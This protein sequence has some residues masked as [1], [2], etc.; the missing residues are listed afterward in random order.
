[1]PIFYR[2]MVIALD[3]KVGTNHKFPGQNQWEVKLRSGDGETLFVLRGSTTNEQNRALKWGRTFW[4]SRIVEGPITSRHRAG[5]F[6]MFFVSLLA[7]VETET[8]KFS[9][10]LKY[11]PYD[12]KAHS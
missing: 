11:P 10:G 2:D 9:V 8:E 1:M 5:R 6:R 12:P 4:W 3:F 7:E